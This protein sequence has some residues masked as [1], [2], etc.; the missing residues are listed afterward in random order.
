MKVVVLGMGGTI[1]GVADAS[2]LRGY[3]AG[4]VAVARLLDG[5]DLATGVELVAEQVAQVDSKDMDEAL[6]LALALRA[7]HWLA[8]DAVAGV[9]VTHGTDTLEETAFF[10]HAALDP[11]KPLVLTGA[12]RPST[13]AAPDGPGNLRDAVAVAADPAARGVLVV[14]AGQVFGASG[15][16][17]VH[18]RD[19]DAFEGGDAG[20]VGRVGAGGFVATGRWP[21]AGA[22]HAPW[23]LEALARRLDEGQGLPWVAWVASHAG[24]T[25]DEVRALLAAGVAGLVVAGTGNA[26][27]HRRLEVALEEARAAGVPVVVGSRC[28]QGDAQPAEAGDRALALT[29]SQ[30]RIALQLRLLGA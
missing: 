1:A 10:L 17:K 5:L 18:P 12:M 13:D 4:E 28:G 15:V 22:E 9:V 30:A 16:R 11:A 27:V 7:R 14:F 21:R 19:V 25:G 24:A 3:R 6:W 29:P 20:P 23:A 2:A 8:Q 26:M